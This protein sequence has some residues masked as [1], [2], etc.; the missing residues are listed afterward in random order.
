MSI[1][2]SRFENCQTAIRN[3]GP[4]LFLTQNL[5]DG[6]VLSTGICSGELYG[7]NF[8]KSCYSRSSKCIED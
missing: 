1:E 7:N 4:S 8:R 3:L 5:I 6:E 2:G